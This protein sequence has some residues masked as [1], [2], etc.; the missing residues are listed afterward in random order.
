[1]DRIINEIIDK[2]EAHT[3]TRPFIVAID[4]LSGAGKTTV[5]QQLENILT[6]QNYKVRVVHIDDHIVERHKRYNTGHDE[7]YEYYYL[8]WDVELLK[9]ELFKKIYLN[10]DL[11]LPF[12][13][14]ETDQIYQE[15]INLDSSS[16]VIIEGIFLQR[17][18]WREYLDYVCYLDCPRDIRFDRVL[19]RDPYNGSHE[20]R[21]QK[22][23]RRYWLGEEHYLHK[24]NPI[25]IADQVIKYEKR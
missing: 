21:L 11:T 16:I 5:T 4:G 6:S 15:K 14:Y 2:Y 17:D 22:Y 18:E 12:Y 19:N 1:M 13:V 23:K 7:W 24:V 10:S 8:Q 9:R 3:K 20:K 25:K